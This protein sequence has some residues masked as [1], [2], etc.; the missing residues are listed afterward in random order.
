MHVACWFCIHNDDDDYGIKVHKIAV[1]DL[2][3]LKLVI[4]DI[5]VLINIVVL[6]VVVYNIFKL[7]GKSLEKELTLFNPCLNNKK[8]QQQQQE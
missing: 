2:V 8:Q 4:H 1:H 3:V 5:V 7:Q 6:Y